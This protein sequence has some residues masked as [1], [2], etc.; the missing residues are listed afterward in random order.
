M[1]IIAVHKDAQQSAGAPRACIS[2]F[3]RIPERSATRLQGVD[4]MR[5]IVMSGIVLVQPLVPAVAAL[6]DSALRDTLITQL[7]HSA[8]HGL[9]KADVSFGL[10]VMLLGMM[11]AI[12]MRRRLMDE[13]TL[14]KIHVQILRRAGALFA[15]GVLYNGG[16]SA[17][18]SDIRWTGVLQR[19]GILYFCGATLYVHLP[20]GLRYVLVPCILLAYWMLLALVPVDGTDPYS[21]EG[22]LAAWV[23]ARLL[24]GRAYYGRWDPEGIVTTLPALASCLIGMM[25]ADLA[26]SG[27]KSSNKVLWLAMAGILAIDIGAMWSDIFP[28]N[29]HLWTSSYVLAVAGIGSVLLAACLLIADV[30]GLARM[31][32]PFIV[33]GRNLLLAFIL[34]ELIAVDSLAKRLVGGDVAV[35]L[36][37]LAPWVAGFVEAAVIWLFLYW[38]YRKGLIVKL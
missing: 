26:T 27:M 12:S 33:V 30:W 25:W 2:E 38:L 29:K 23:D 4:A 10:F 17:P 28:I 7:H 35:A 8:W 24:P 15:L 5:G 11:I 13:T 32:F 21:F 36:G 31:L 37:Q 14:W 20:R 9:T 6:P 18:W 34:P 1:R 19:L 22:N 16:F 3:S